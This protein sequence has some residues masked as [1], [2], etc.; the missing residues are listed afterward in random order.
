MFGRRRKKKDGQ[1]ADGPAETAGAGGAEGD[2]A[3]RPEDPP[4]PEKEADR[5]RADG[6]WDSAEDAPEEQRMDLGAVR[7]PVRTGIEV[8]VNV[9]SQQ[10][11]IIGVTLRTQ[12]SA[13]QVQP[14]AAPKSS[15][16]WSEMLEE[17]RSQVTSQGGKVDDFEGTFGPELRAVVPVAGKKD[18]QGRQL[19]ERVRFIG[20]DGPR[21]VLH[22]VIRGDGA[23]KPE[24]MA[25]VEELFQQIVVAR[26][27]APAP[28][29][30]MLAIVVPQEIQQSMAQAAQ[31]RRSAGDGQSGQS[32]GG[33]APE[34]GG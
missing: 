27:D 16:I 20:V 13:L 4:E 1:G 9:A 32:G 26:G 34:S 23:S 33:Q 24:A 22:G 11:R 3:G 25:E 21:W 17:L 6:P 2:F 5:H 15:G 19:G 18:D 28:P 7:I 29:R 12:S 10:N 8:Q 14:F 30:E 31:Q